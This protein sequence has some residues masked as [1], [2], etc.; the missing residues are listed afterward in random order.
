MINTYI[1]T[2]VDFIFFPS[3]VFIYNPNSFYSCIFR[4]NFF[5]TI[6]ILLNSSMFISQKL[7][8]Q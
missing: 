7:L 5:S 1:N 3:G 6:S 8:V 2:E 4:W